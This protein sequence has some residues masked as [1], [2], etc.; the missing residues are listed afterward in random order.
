MANE[1]PQSNL[2]HAE[3]SLTFHST[4]QSLYS[5]A[6][7]RFLSASPPPRSSKNNP[8]FGALSE[9]SVTTLTDDED[10]EKTIRSLGLE[11]SPK[12]SIGYSKPTRSATFPLLPSHNDHNSNGYLTSNV[13]AS[14]SSPWIP[15]TPFSSIQTNPLNNTEGYFSPQT[16]DQ[17][18][19]NGLFESNVR[20]SATIS[21]IQGN[22]TIH[23]DGHVEFAHG[24]GGPLDYNDTSGVST[25]A[26][27]P[28]SPTNYLSQSHFQYRPF[29]N[30][31]QQTQTPQQSQQSQ[32]LQYQQ[33]QLHTSVASD[34]HSRLD[35]NGGIVTDDG[36][37]GSM[38]LYDPT[39]SDEII[40][41]NGK[42]TTGNDGKDFNNELKLDIRSLQTIM[43]APPGLDN[44]LSPAS[45]RSDH[46]EHY[47]SSTMVSGLTSPS[48]ANVNSGKNI[49]AN[50]M[51]GNGGGG[52]TIND[53]TNSLNSMNINSNGIEM[54]KETS[55]DISNVQVSGQSISNK[56]Q[57][58]SWAA[59]AKTRPQPPPPVNTSQEVIGGTYSAAISPSSAVSPSFANRSMSAPPVTWTSKTKIV[60]TPTGNGIGSIYTTNPMMSIPPTPS[61][62]KKD[63]SSF[64]AERG[65]NPKA[66]NCKPQNAR[67]FVIKSYTEDDV[68]KSLKY[69]IWAS[70]EIGN[71]RLDK[72]FRDNADKG[73]IYL[74]FSVNASGHFCGMAEMLTPVDYTTSSN[75]WQ[76][77]KWKGVFK[78]KWIFVKD[79]PNG[80][81]RHIRIV[82]N[83]NKPVTN[84]RDT[85]E[86]YL[87]P[88]RE[89]L[90][91][92][93]D[94][95]S[96]TSILDDFEFY[97]KR[98][99]EMRKEGTTPVGNDT[100]GWLPSA[101]SSLKQS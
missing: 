45:P 29:V 71:R 91:I 93:F 50:D 33:F 61:T 57:K 41:D 75:V 89:M 48:L 92:F 68:H 27:T 77:D 88:G 67:F 10:C 13:T 76:Q 9:K 47:F 85:Q 17:Y 69:D 11:D 31:L 62:S 12:E 46:A 30:P 99:Q 49:F 55:P 38:A 16:P 64:M 4:Q 8:G 86:L 34:L 44:Y 81:L 24:L 26:V 72:A 87:E 80:Q 60:G 54:R 83:E 58:Q 14:T 59:V 94:Y 2:S 84:S 82:N 42:F 65:Y 5:S 15:S 70:T 73:P 96:K 25:S 32:Q 79:I 39:N 37:S 18:Y 19:N 51:A 1:H 100:N 35:S 95:R 53:L 78:V 66:F 40:R 56:Q 74:F 6:F 52:Q 43:T 3:K 97:D 22:G 36:V 98:Q 21:N 63:M 101:N 7:N 90:K 28:S 20:R 23:D